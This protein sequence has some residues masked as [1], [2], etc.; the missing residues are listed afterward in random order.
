MPP[1]TASSTC[2]SAW[3]SSPRSFF[4]SGST[5]RS[6]ASFTRW[7][8]K[9]ADA[10]RARSC[11]FC[12]RSTAP[13]SPSCCSP[14]PALSEALLGS[15]AQ[16]NALRLMLVNT[17]AIGFT[18]IPF[19]VLRIEQRTRTFS[20]L[21]LARSVLTIVVRLVLVMKLGMGVTGLYLADLLVTV[22][23]LAALVPWFVP[24]IRPMFSAETL[25]EL[26]AAFGLPRVPA[27]GRAADHRDR[28]QVHP[29]I[30]RAHGP[31]GRLRPRGLCRS[32]PE[33]VP[34]RLRV[35]VGAVLLRD[36]PRTRCAARVPH[37]VHLWR[38][39]AGA[40]DGRHLRHRPRRAQGDDARPH[41]AAVRPALA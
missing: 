4:A 11:S 16:V 39:G 3:R 5:A 14:H 19:H 18:F 35:G 30:L 36:D 40:P 2:S 12:W 7:M 24:L 6:C 9:A 15:R 20:L 37:G 28:R 8:T 34:Q 10:W 25:R 31:G 26:A 1:T 33:A 21:T 13:C 22:V 38:R 17:F 29:A 41:P 32:R 27:R 23:I